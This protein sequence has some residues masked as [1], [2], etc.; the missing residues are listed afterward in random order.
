[1]DAI[2]A[3]SRSANRPRCSAGKILLRAIFRHLP[4]F[5]ES[6]TDLNQQFRPVF[7]GNREARKR[8]GAMR[9]AP[10]REDRRQGLAVGGIAGRGCVL[11]HVASSS[12]LSTPPFVAWIWL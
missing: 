7:C 2:N 3:G 12:R 1:M 11:L 6:R 8:D 5:L 4:G 9:G 10:T